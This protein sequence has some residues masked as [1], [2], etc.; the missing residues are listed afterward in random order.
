MKKS[1]F[2]VMAVFCLFSCS[3]TNFKLVGVSEFQFLDGKKVYLVNLDNVYLDSAE[4]KN[5]K[6]VIDGICDSVQLVNIVCYFS[7]DL[8]PVQ[9]TFLFE[10]GT[11][12]IKID[13]AGD[14]YVEGSEQNSVLTNYMF[15]T[16]ELDKKYE[17]ALKVSQVDADRVEAEYYE[18]AYQFA[19]SQS[20]NLVGKYIFLD[21]YNGMTTEQREEITSLM[22][23]D[24]KKDEKVAKIINNIQR[25]KLVAKGM[26]Y[27]DFAL[28]DPQ[29]NTLALSS[30]VGKSDYL[31]IDF[32]ASWCPYCIKSFPALKQVYDRYHGKKFE[33]LG[34]SLD[35]DD[36]KWTSAIERYALNWLHVS[37][38]KKWDCEPAK[39][40]VVYGIPATV[41][42]DKTGKIA[43]RNLTAIE[44]EEIILNNPN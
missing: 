41:L 43:G 25:E 8:K 14:V 5:G 26:Q 24:I 16:K 20:Q 30:L 21:Q 17:Q 39:L 29:G 7:P 10:Q 33:I 23:E 18:L 40:Y 15:K 38:L 36:N 2:A 1:I 42:I 3:K 6:F 12:D 27:L 9:R 28:P 31:L 32:W 35:D 22:S 19:K 34:V 13:S 44:I 11:T 37:D 4:I